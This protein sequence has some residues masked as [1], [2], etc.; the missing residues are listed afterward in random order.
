M[1]SSLREEEPLLVPEYESLRNY[2]LGSLDLPPYVRSVP[3]QRRFR[4]GKLEKPCR[5]SNKAVLG[6]TELK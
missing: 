5:W 6:S 2:G 1:Q 4:P 3:N